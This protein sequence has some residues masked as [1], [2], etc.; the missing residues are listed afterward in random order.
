MEQHLVNMALM[1]DQAF[2][3]FSAELILMKT[4]IMSDNYSDVAKKQK[5]NK[6]RISLSGVEEKNGSGNLFFGPGGDLRSVFEQSNVQTPYGGIC[7]ALL[8]RLLVG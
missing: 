4:L 6:T 7:T 5:K 3:P 1:R 8:P 2:L